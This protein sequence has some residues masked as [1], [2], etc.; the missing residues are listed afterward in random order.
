MKEKSGSKEEGRRKESLLNT[1]GMRMLRRIKSVTLR[2]RERSLS[3]DI[4]RDLRMENVTGC[5]G[6][7]TFCGWMKKIRWKCEV[8]GQTEHQ[9]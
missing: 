6:M 4:R 2:D 8:C 7:D 5:T 3:I 1:R 9:E